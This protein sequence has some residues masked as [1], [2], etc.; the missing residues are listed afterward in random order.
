MH[1][2]QV[3]YTKDAQKPFEAYFLDQIPFK[4]AKLAVCM[5]SKEIHDS[6]LSLLRFRCP[7]EKCEFVS[8]SGWDELKRHANKVHHKVMW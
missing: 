2:D 4:D 5:E 8:H 7:S 1:M 6:I 3:V